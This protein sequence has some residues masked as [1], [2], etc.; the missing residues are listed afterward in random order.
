MKGEISSVVI[1]HIK[2]DCCGTQNTVQISSLIKRYYIFYPDKLADTLV[3][4]TRI[5][6]NIREAVHLVQNTVSKSVWN[7]CIYQV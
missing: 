1:H 5:A 4:N 2:R 6:S 7:S 3:R